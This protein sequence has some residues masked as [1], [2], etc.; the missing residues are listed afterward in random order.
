[1]ANAGRGKNSSGCGALIVA[2]IVFA[3]VA[4]VIGQIARG[5]T[6]LSIWMQY[7]SA[8]LPDPLDRSPAYPLAWGLFGCLL[9]FLGLAT[10][11]IVYENS[12][13]TRFKAYVAKLE[14][15]ALPA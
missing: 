8:G 4:A 13:R 12:R 2:F 5:F 15:P 11:A 9:T 14:R 1:M 3:L 7:G 6:N 10:I